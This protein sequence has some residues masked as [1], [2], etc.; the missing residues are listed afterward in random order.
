M[1][2]FAVI[3]THFPNMV[4]ASWISRIR[5][6]PYANQKRKIFSIINES[7]SKKLLFSQR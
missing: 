5:R 3:G 6:G 2:I 4:N 7:Y 1:A